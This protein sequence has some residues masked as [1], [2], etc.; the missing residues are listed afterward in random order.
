MSLKID[1]EAVVRATEAPGS[2][3]GQ[4]G[5]PDGTSAPGTKQSKAD[6]ALDKE[7]SL[8]AA[9]RREMTKRRGKATEDEITEVRRRIAELS[10]YNKRLRSFDGDLEKIVAGYRTSFINQRDGNRHHQELMNKLGLAQPPDGRGSAGGTGGMFMQAGR[11]ML[12]ATGMG[13]GVSGGIISNAAHMAGEAP[14]GMASAGGL[15]MLAKGAGI[16]ALAYVGIKAVQKVGQKVGDAQDESVQ[17]SDLRHAVGTTSVGFDELRASVRHFTASLGVSSAESAKLA[18]SYARS[19]QVFGIAAER[20]VGQA[21]GHGAQLSRGYGLAPEAGVEF[22]ATMRHF[23]AGDGTDKDNRKLAYLIGDAVGKTGAFSKADDVMNAIAHFTESTSR[24]SLQV[25]NVEGFAGMLGA[26]GGLKLPGMDAKG[27]ANIMQQVA[28]SWAHGGGEAGQ[29]M[30]LGWASRFGATAMDMGAIADAGPLASAESTFGK[31]SSLYKLAAGDEKRQ[32]RLLEMAKK[33]GSST[34]LDKEIGMIKEQYGAEFVPL[35]LSSKYGVSDIGARSLLK[36]SEQGGGLSGLQDRISGRLN[37]TNLDPKK[38]SLAQTGMLSAIDQADTS[39]L[40]AMK[41]KAMKLSGKNAL[42]AEEKKTLSGATGDDDLKKI[43]TQINAFRESEDEGKSARQ[44]QIDLDRKFQEFAAK[45]IPL[46]T[47]IQE[48]VFGLLDKAGGL[49]PEM[50]QFEA[51][52]E[53]RKKL[54]DKKTPEEKE[55]LQDLYVKTAKRGPMSKS[56]WDTRLAAIDGEFKNKKIDQKEREKRTRELSGE[57]KYRRDAGG[58][59]VPDEIK[60]IIADGERGA[61]ESPAKSPSSPS[62]SSARDKVIAEAK[63]QGL[64]AAETDAVLRLVQLESG[65][66]EDAVGSEIKKGMH[67]G[68]RAYGLFQYMAKSSEGWDRKNVDQNIQHGIADFKRR[69]RQYGI[70]GAIA[71]HHAGSGAL[72]KDG[73]LRR[74]SSDGN[75]KTSEYLARING[76]KSAPDAAR[77]ANSGDQSFKVGG[78]VDVNIRHPDGSI[79]KQRAPLTG[80]SQTSAGMSRG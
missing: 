13:G 65:F 29:N 68:D 55:A 44:A 76:D 80:F 19:S 34:F 27:A 9:A 58:N 20:E 37:G 79:E 46:T 17:Y 74:D 59:S 51:N 1:V 63:K 2:S 72:N 21:V 71:G 4:A 69:S 8:E 22:L 15:S 14:G 70:D 16:A 47:M 24:Q 54:D 48:G 49:T 5:K 36:A 32:A 31:D 78:A 50:K 25:A 23:K 3:A 67:K 38:I 53:Y 26:L 77:S 41:S 18:N 66:K 30:R 52:K 28:G 73:S 43:L 11:G 60:K 33:G 12:R 61:G 10:K 62:S 42:T 39:E 56:E 75:M 7:K 45:I 6:A 64:S 57:E 40:A 35:S